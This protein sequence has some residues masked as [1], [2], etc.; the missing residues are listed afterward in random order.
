[1]KLTFCCAACAVIM[2]ALPAFP[3][4]LPGQAVYDKTCKNCHGD[5]GEGSPTADQFF[6][7]NIPRLNSEFVQSKSDSEIEKIIKG[8]KGKMPPVKKP[9]P[10]VSPARPRTMGVPPPTNPH[11]K[12]LDADEIRDVIAYI[13]TFRK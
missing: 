2:L 13:R 5:K 10:R 12:K 3:A 11:G 9:D 1:M 8:G 4:P 6:R 7:T